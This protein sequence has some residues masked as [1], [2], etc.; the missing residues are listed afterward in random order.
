MNGVVLCRLHILELNVH[1]FMQRG[2]SIEMNCQFARNVYLRVSIGWKVHWL[3]NIPYRRFLRLIEIE[4]TQT[5]HMVTWTM[6]YSKVYMKI[7][8]IYP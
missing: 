7:V 6:K 1:E 3:A 2:H 4:K 8:F 5:K